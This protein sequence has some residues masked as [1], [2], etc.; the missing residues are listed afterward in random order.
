MAPQKSDRYQR[1]LE[2][3]GARHDRHRS[4]MN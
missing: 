2:R 4:P 3:I 1:N